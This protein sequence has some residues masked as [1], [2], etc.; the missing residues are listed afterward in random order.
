MKLIKN[1]N[2]IELIRFLSELKG[3][4]NM[5]TLIELQKKA[6]EMNL[7]GILLYR[8]KYDINSDEWELLNQLKANLIESQKPSTKETIVTFKEED[9]M[10]IVSGLSVVNKTPP[11]KFECKRR[12]LIEYNPNY[13]HPIPYC[14]IRYEDKYFVTVRENKSG[15]VRLIGKMGLPGGHVAAGD[16][17]VGNLRRT[18]ARGLLRELKEETGVTLGMIDDIALKGLIK[19]NEG[20]DADHLGFIYE[21]KL[22]TD[23]IKAEESGVLRGMWIPKSELL[24]YENKFESWLKMVY[25]KII[26]NDNLE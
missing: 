9:L 8:D 21:V 19:G 26:V 23:K 20:V 22:R 16:V 13:R 10:R 15:E 24:K 11:I 5:M 25:Y 7:E 1:D 4:N 12:S 18:L 3:E 14:I 6:L 2:G 17:L